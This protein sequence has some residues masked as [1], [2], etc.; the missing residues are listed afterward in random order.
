MAKEVNRRFVAV[1]CVHSDH[2][3]FP[4][5]T[6]QVSIDDS[7][8]ANYRAGLLAA[9]INMGF[10][11]LKEDDCGAHGPVALRARIVDLT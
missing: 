11:T 8:R 1:W 10:G 7:S 9:M 2:D 6:N 3:E 4:L 5:L